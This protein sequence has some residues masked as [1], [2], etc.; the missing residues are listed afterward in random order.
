MKFTTTALGIVL[1]IASMPAA[2]QLTRSQENDK[3]MAQQPQSKPGD[4]KP[5]SG[6][7]KAIVE[8][9]N[10]VKANDTANIPAKL[11]AA[12][13]VAKT[14]EDNYL[15][16]VFQ[17]QAALNA[18]DVAGLATAVQALEASSYLDATKLAALY[19][20]LGIQQFN[21][22]QMALAVASFQRAATLTPNDY[23][24]IELLAQAKSAAG[25]N[26]EAASL[27]QQTIKARIAAGQ[28]PTEDVYR[29]A[30]QAAYDSQSPAAIE[31]G[32]DWVAAYPSPDSWRNAILI[33]RNLVKPD[34]E[35]TLDLLRLMQTMNAL[36]KSADY[37]LFATAAADQQ[38]FV[39]AQAVIDAGIAAKQVDPASPL[40]RD[41]VVGLKSKQKLTEA[42]LVEAVKIAQT[43][44]AMVRVGDRYFGMGQYAKAA[45]LYRKA[46]AKGGVDKDVAN[47]HLGMALARSNDKAGAT[48]AFNAVTGPR[49]DIAKY[50]LLYLRGA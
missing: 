10:A 29:R 18:K 50:W 13:A 23:G 19:M 9:Q 3:P 26:A 49:A 21:A 2:A 1:A 15:I 6:A 42:D 12:R 25:Q 46:L 8:L 24:A 36:S 7:L 14:K 30:V 39:E 34:V 48:A 27:F 16:G 32:R 20:D 40:F 37:N 33:Y 41:I 44:A 31:L 47:I 17:R 35:G 43:G 45:D 11:A 28:K 4:V 38:N 22:K 5:S